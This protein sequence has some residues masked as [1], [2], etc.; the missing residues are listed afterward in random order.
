MAVWPPPDVLDVVAALPRPEVRGVRWTT[1]EQWHITLRFLGECAEGVAMDALARVDVDAADATLGPETGRFGRRIVHVPVAGL[2]DV[3]AAVAAAFDGV[4]ADP[5]DRPFHGHLTLAR[6]RA[7]GR[8]APDL[9]PLCGV[10]VH[11]AWRPNDLVL[12]RSTPGS[13]AHHYDTIATRA[14]E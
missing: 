5:E 11:A 1:P 14:L 10:P 8:A 7:R 9:R 4:G 2:D 13:G 6:G 3:A 12:V